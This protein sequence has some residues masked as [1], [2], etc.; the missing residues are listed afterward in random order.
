MLTLYLIQHAEARPK[1]EDPERSISDI[2]RINMEK[3]ANHLAALS[4]NINSILHSGKLRAKQSA[5]ILFN[6]TGA[7]R[8]SEAGGLAPNDEPAG[9]IER[10][11]DMT[12]S[13]ILVGHLPHLERLASTLI[14]GDAASKAVAFRNAGILCLK[15][16]DGSA[17][18]VEWLITPDSLP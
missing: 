9:W 14:C 4:P 10:L 13:H 12:G 5:E 18:S 1:E 8:I 6:K 11:G 2:G 17:W 15:K 7:D 16:T 3:T